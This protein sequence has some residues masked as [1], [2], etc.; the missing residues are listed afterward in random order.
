MFADV[1]IKNLRSGRKKSEMHGSLI[2]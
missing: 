1:M 2:K